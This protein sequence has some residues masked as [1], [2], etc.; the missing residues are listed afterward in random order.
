MT[1]EPS[2]AD[3]ELQD[4]LARHGM[5]TD[6]APGAEPAGMFGLPENKYMKRRR[7]DAANARSQKKHQRFIRPENAAA[8]IANL[9]EPGETLHGILRGDF[10]L[11][12]IMEPMLKRG[13]CP[14]LLVGTLSM[15][16]NN[17]QTFV[18][19]FQENLV[20]RITLVISHYFTSVNKSTIYS[21]IRRILESTKTDI[22]VMRSHAKVIVM[23]TAENNYVIESSANLRS[24]DN[25]E[26]I[27]IFNDPDVAAFHA[28]WISYVLAHPPTT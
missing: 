27:T 3:Q 13:R 10:V 25:L 23:Q 17:A 20:D 14:H 24:S 2:A 7:K 26:Q 16:V 9:P 5:A 21:E 22:V 15:S 28:D 6:A 18:K 1:P 4:M 8:L 11:A 12:D 19:L